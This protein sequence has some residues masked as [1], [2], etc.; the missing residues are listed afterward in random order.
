MGVD[1]LE[2]IEMVSSLEKR[3]GIK[4]PQEN[5]SPSYSGFLMNRSFFGALLEAEIESIAK[6]Y[7]HLNINRLRINRT[8]NSLKDSFT[9]ESIIK[10]IESKLVGD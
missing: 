8:V 2:Y 7:P 9:V 5:L 4:I 10:Y 3:F 6:S 1:S